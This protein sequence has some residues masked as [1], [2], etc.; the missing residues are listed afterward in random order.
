MPLRVIYVPVAEFEKSVV[1]VM[2]GDGCVVERRGLEV[3]EP[4]FGGTVAVERDRESWRE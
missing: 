1:M 4:G 2:F 3:M